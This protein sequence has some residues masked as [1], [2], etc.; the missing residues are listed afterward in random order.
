MSK[1]VPENWCAVARIAK[2]IETSGPSNIGVGYVE[3][4]F[5]QDNPI[6]RYVD[7]ITG[8]TFERRVETAYD[9]FCK[10]A[11][12]WPSEEDRKS[13]VTGKRVSVSVDLGGR[14]KIKK[15]KKKK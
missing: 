11:K 3:G 4:T 12:I 10:Q 8:F 15:K 13:V 7:G 2:Q 6:T 5:T 9:Q 14:V 1:D